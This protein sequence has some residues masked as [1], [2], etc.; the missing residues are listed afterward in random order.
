MGVLIA[1]G[2]AV[3]VWKMVDLAKQ[4]AARTQGAAARQE[5]K[6]PPLA[7]G[8]RFEAPFAF[9]LSLEPDERILETTPAAAGLW[10]R[11]G[12][13]GVTQRIILVDDAGRIIGSIQVKHD[14]ATRPL[15]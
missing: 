14:D 13:G 6:A 4:K 15:R 1:L 10:L 12:R 2:L 3:V 8:R 7:A 9:D 11:I 5:R